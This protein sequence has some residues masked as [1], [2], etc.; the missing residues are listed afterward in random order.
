MLGRFY[1]NL[2]KLWNFILSR[3]MTCAF[4][5][6]GKFRFWNVSVVVRN[7]E[8]GIDIDD[9]NGR[10]GFYLGISITFWMWWISSPLHL[11]ST[12]IVTGVRFS[13]L[14]FNSRTV[15]GLRLESISFSVNV[16]YFA[17]TSF[18]LPPLRFFVAQNF[19]L[20]FLSFYEAEALLLFHLLQFS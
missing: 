17:E 15:F 18:P 10:F 19:V 8:V 2:F 11:L 14:E 7:F 13:A 5:H 12:D 6:I 16:S 9:F 1:F 4:S 3:G 20:D